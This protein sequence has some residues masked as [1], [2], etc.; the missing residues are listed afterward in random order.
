MLSHFSHV[1]LSVT[2]WTVVRQAPLSMGFSR[3]EDWS[4]LPCPPP[5]DLLDPGIEP[6][7]PMSPALRGRFFT[8][9]TTWEAHTYRQMGTYTYM[10]AIKYI[11]IYLC[12]DMTYRQSLHPRFPSAS[13]TCTAR[14]HLKLDHFSHVLELRE[15]VVI[16]V[17]ELLV[18]FLFAVLQACIRV[19]FPGGAI[20]KEPT[21]QCRRPKRPGFNPWVKKI[22]WRREWLHSPVFLPGKIP[23]TEELGRL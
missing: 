6:T 8:I 7:S 5:G 23:R 20:G 19:G 21:C 13:F 12:V 17:Q 16:K 4:G 22:P 1:R 10:C 18:G 15:H 9:S 11:H 3:Q 2:P 14:A